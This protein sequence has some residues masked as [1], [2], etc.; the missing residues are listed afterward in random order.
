[1]GI[2]VDAWVQV[3]LTFDG[4]PIENLEEGHAVTYAKQVAQLIRTLNEQGV[5]DIH[6]FARIPAAL[7]VLIGQRLLACGRIHLYW[8]DNPTYRFAFTLA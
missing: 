4:K 5:T 7:A 6:L 2:T 8:F 1:M 3:L